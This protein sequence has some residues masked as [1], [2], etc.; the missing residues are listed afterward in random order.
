MEVTKISKK[1]LKFTEEEKKEAKR[2]FQFL[3]RLNR[4]LYNCD[5]T[6][7]EYRFV[8]DEDMFYT[9]KDLHGVRT[10]LLEIMDSGKLEME[11]L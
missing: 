3:M 10:L 2:M 8:V 11:N 7:S 5:R 1:V 4:E 6:K 9:E